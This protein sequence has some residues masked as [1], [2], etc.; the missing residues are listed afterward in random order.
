MG[1]HDIVDAARD[2]LGPIPVLL[3]GEPHA[4]ARH[5]VVEPMC[6]FFAS[7]CEQFWTDLT[8]LHH[9]EAEVCVHR[10]VHLCK[11]RQGDSRSAVV[12]RPGSRLL[13]E[14]APHAHSLVFGLDAHLFD[15]CVSVNVVDEQ[16]ADRPVTAIAGDQTTTVVRVCH[17]YFDRS[18]FVIGDVVREREPSPSATLDLRQP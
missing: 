2:R 13:D 15:V 5:E 11:G 7:Y 3:H 1:A 8:I 14:T 6:H 17:E 10:R 4:H 18:R 9:G 12:L 16:K